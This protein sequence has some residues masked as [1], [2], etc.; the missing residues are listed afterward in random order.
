MRPEAVKAV[1]RRFLCENLEFSF[2]SMI[3]E[4]YGAVRS[5]IPSTYILLISCFA[6]E[7]SLESHAHVRRHGTRNSDFWEFQV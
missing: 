6:M 5:L 1:R 7:V 4:L 3:T 2:W